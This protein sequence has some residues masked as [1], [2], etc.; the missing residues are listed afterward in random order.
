MREEEVSIGGAE[1]ATE[2]AEAAAPES[3]ERGEEESEEAEAV[4]VNVALLEA[5]IRRTEVLEKLAS[6][7]ITPADAEKLL[8]EVAAPVATSGRRRRRRK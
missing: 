8:A 5:M 2:E 4:D 6:G 1:E 7:A 3:A